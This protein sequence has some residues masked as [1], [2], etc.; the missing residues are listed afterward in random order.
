MRLLVL[1]SKMEKTV[2]CRQK[3][4]GIL[5]YSIIIT[6]VVLLVNDSEANRHASNA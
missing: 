6:F 5:N 4:L 3:V 1:N 2:D